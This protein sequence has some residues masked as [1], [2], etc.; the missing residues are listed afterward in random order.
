[1][2][3]IRFRHSEWCRKKPQWQSNT[4]EIRLRVLQPNTQNKKWKQ[5]VMLSELGAIF[6]S[7]TGVTGAA[8]GVRLP[9][10]ARAVARAR[11]TPRQPVA[12][13]SLTLSVRVRIC[14]FCS[15][16]KT[17]WEVWGE[18][19]K[20]AITEQSQQEEMAP[21]WLVGAFV[22]GEERGPRADTTFAAQITGFLLTSVPS[23][24]DPNCNICKIK[25]LAGPTNLAVLKP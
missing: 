15:S 8:C 14:S 5:L 20:P 23:V 18:T 24:V 9:A 4:D 13:S 17:N 11:S 10:Q 22:Q 6:P 3:K 25:L 7:W 21:C 16:V 12:R 1:M 2:T 19:D